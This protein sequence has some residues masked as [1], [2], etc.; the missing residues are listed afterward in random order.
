MAKTRKISIV[1]LSVLLFSL[2]SVCL[3][4][5]AAA[6]NV[7]VRA[8]VSS[9]QP[10]VGDTLTVTI[11][12]SNA[13]DVYGVDVALDWNPAVL[14]AI[15]ATP[16][17]GVESHSGGVLHE[18]E[19]YPIDVEDDSLTDG[20]YHLLATSVG[21]S[22]PGFSGDGTIATVEFNITS[23][24]STGL[25]LDNVELA[26]KGNENPVDPSTSVDSVNVVVPE[27]PVAAIIVGIVVAS[28]TVVA[29]TKLFK[30]KMLAPSKLAT[31]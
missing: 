21:A 22:T 20:Q 12:L 2:I 15:S 1:V 31:L 29:A 16:I 6:Q 7:T 10:Q 23:A 3:V 17:L 13:Q 11:K 9:S 25:A 4:F 28:V 14:R 26:I 24:G 5:G 8:E 18:S 27:F 19:T 30:R